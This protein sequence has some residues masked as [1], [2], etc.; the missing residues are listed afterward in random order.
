MDPAETQQPEP[1]PVDQLMAVVASHNATISRHEQLLTSQEAAVAHHDQFWGRF[2]NPCKPWR[3]VSHLSHPSWRNPS[4]PAP[5][6]SAPSPSGDPRQPAPQAMA[7][8]EPRLPAPQQYDGNPAECCGFLTQCSLTFELQPSTLNF[9]YHNFTAEMRSVFDHPVGGREAASWLFQ[10]HQGSS[11]VSEYA[12]HFHTLAAESNWNAKALIA[13]FQHGL[14]GSIKDELAT[15]EPAAN[16]E[17]LIY[18]AIRLLPEPSCTAS[19]PH[20]LCH[21]ESPS[22]DTVE[23]MQ[24][25]GT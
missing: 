1:T 16:L 25:G 15:K 23:P 17:A 2:S 7:S 3:L 6:P 24:L 9:N 14:S 5:E 4:Q 8:S 18:Q 10:L 22:S 19:C 11:S 12:V 20:T 13:A 21:W